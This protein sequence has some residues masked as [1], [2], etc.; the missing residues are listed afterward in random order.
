MR[1]NHTA[2]YVT[3]AVALFGA[4]LLGTGF[5][6]T[7]ASASSGPLIQAAEQVEARTTLPRQTITATTG[8]TGVA[9]ITDVTTIT[10]VAGLTETTAVTTGNAVSDT[11]PALAADS[12]YT[13]VVEGTIIANRTDAAVRFFVEGETTRLDAQRA[14]GLDLTRITAVLNLYNCDADTPEGD[15]TCY[16][17]P[18][19]LN[20]DGFYEIVAGAEEDLA[21]GLVLREAGSPP[22]NQIWIQNRTGK[23]ETVVYRNETYEL[24]PA[25][26]QEF[27]VTDDALPIFFLRSCINANGES[28]CEWAPATAQAGFYYSL[29]EQSAAG[30][31]PGSSFTELIIKPVM[32]KAAGVAMPEA[33][34]GDAPAADAANDTTNDAAADSAATQEN[35]G[36]TESAAQADEIACTLLVPALNVRSGPGLQYEIVNKVRGDGAEPATVIIVG[37]SED[38]SWLAVDERIA[39]G[40]WITGSAGYLECNNDVTALGIAAITDGRLAPTPE[41][42]EPVADSAAAPDSG[43]EGGESSEVTATEPTTG[44]AQASPAVPAGLAVLQVRNDFEQV[45]RFTIDQK[46]RVEQG[47]SEADLQP[48]DSA[49][50][51]IYPGMVA[52]SASTPWRGLSGNS[53]MLVESDQLRNLKLTFVPDPD[54]SDKWNLL[55]WE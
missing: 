12:A 55:V 48:G 37:R 36:Q 5:N 47:P 32:G 33:E 42:V 25:T 6:A 30:G 29:E 4:L 43:T 8:V 31:L 41:P 14:L 49:A 22:S 3:I 52:F 50:Y 10:D 34:D 9:V 2:L 23:R 46:F 51:V 1:T 16:W 39:D 15:E 28:A 27:T 26:V 44:T 40:G 11:A 21:A 53:D 24:L 45:I 54:E 19:L 38:N 13:A 35:A 17:D 18:Y 20:R 7:P